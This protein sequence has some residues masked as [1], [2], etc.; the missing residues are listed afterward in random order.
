M[1]KLLTKL[2]AKQKTGALTVDKKALEKLDWF[3]K[4]LLEYRNKRE[5]LKFVKALLE[6]QEGGK[7]HIAIKVPGTFSGRCSAGK[8]D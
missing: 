3:G 1:K 2:S 5:E 7:I 6:N 4:L 8:V